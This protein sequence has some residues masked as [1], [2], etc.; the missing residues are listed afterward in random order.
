L[1]EAKRAR[2][3]NFAAELRQGCARIRSTKSYGNI[4]SEICE[5]IV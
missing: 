5:M 1:D 3:I 4:G 2:N